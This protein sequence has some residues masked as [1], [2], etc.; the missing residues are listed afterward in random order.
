MQGSID[1]SIQDL[2][3]YLETHQDEKALELV[4]AA[5]NVD[6]RG[7]ICKGAIPDYFEAGLHDG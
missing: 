3:K 7:Q 6:G 5:I 1:D 4:R 2:S